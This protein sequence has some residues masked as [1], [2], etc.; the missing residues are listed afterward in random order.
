MPVRIVV[1][2][3]GRRVPVSFLDGDVVDIGVA[4]LDRDDLVV[5]SLFLEPAPVVDVAL[6]RL[7]LANEIEPDALGETGGGRAHDVN[8]PAAVLLSATAAQDAVVQK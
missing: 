7:L 4:A 5:P 8:M 1:H 2:E 3:A 6:E